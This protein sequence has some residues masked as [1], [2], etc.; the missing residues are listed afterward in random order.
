MCLCRCKTAPSM[1]RCTIYGSLW[2]QGLV[3]GL[4]MKPH[5]AAVVLAVGTCTVY[6]TCM[7]LRMC[8]CRCKIAPS[9]DRCTIYG[10]L[11]VQDLVAGLF[12]KPE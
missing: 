4:F 5:R 2:V 6:V 10:S 11:W 7:R 12:M 3:A 1:D 9:M 8:L